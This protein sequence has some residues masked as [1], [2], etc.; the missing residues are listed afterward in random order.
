MLNPALLVTINFMFVSLICNTQRTNILL[1]FSAT[2]M[3]VC[4]TDCN[5][6]LSPHTTYL[7]IIYIFERMPLW[8]IH[9]SPITTDL[10]T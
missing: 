5:Y 2:F 9:K 8:I 7:K 10:Y 4:L 1:Q 6:I 3:C